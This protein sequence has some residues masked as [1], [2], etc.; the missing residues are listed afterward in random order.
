MAALTARFAAAAR[1]NGPLP[2]LHAAA[3]V[4]RQATGP[5]LCTAMRFDA[6]AMTVRRLF[7]SNPGAY[8]VGGAKPKRDTPWGRIVLLER[9]VFVGEGEN[10]IRQHFDDHALIL[11]LGLRSVVNVPVLLRGGCVGTLNLLWPEP[12]VDPERRAL[13]ELLGLLVAPDWVE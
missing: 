1:E 2:L 8:P 7:S 13:A 9:E 4:A 12:V 3:E 6:A 10:A 11:S 5:G